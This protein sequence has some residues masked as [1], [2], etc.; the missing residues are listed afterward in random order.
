VGAALDDHFSTHWLALAGVVLGIAIGVERV[1]QQRYWEAV[2][3]SGHHEQ[4]F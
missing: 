4:R 3:S 2:A 1:I